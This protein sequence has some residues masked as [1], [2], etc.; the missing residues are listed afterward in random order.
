MFHRNTLPLDSRRNLYHNSLLTYLPTST[1]APLSSIFHTS[2]E[3]PF[4]LKS[5][6]NLISL[7]CLTNC[8]YDSARTCTNHISLHPLCSSNT[9]FLSMAWTYHAGFWH[10]AFVKACSSADIILDSWVSASSPPQRSLHI[11]LFNKQLLESNNYFL[12][13]HLHSFS[14][15]HL[16]WSHSFLCCYFERLSYF[17]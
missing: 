10:R 16:L 9:G 14:T 13:D 7:L 11:M 3:I 6:N 12:S 1:L 2:A 17:Y 5:S 8:V 4:Y 15:Y